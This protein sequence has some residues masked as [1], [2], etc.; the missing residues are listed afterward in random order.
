MTDDGRWTTDDGKLTKVGHNSSPEHFVLRWPKNIFSY[1]YLCFKSFV[2]K[3]TLKNCILKKCLSTVYLLKRIVLF[4]RVIS[5]KYKE[6]M[7]ITMMLSFYK[8]PI[9]LK[10][11]LMFKTASWDIW[12]KNVF[13]FF[14]WTFFLD[15]F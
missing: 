4:P 8:W 14:I 13:K 3:M 7:V 11:K 10:Y 9:F 5:Q 15:I 12:A 1:Q 6:K 2:S